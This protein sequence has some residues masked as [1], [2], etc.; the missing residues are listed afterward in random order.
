MQAALAACV[1][2]TH[3][4]LSYGVIEAGG[5]SPGRVSG[6][7]PQRLSVG[8]MLT[9]VWL[10]HMGPVVLIDLQK[11]CAEAALGGCDS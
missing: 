6:V 10:R 2:Q 9:W 11:P 4:R 8:F 7:T 1:Y 3:L 5:H